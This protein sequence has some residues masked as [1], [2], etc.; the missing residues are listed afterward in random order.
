M[1]KSRKRHQKYVFKKTGRKKTY[2]KGTYKK[3]D[4]SYFKRLQNTVNRFKRA[5]RVTE[6]ERVALNR[7]FDENK[8]NVNNIMITKKDI[9]K[10]HIARSRDHA[11]EEYIFY[12]YDGVKKE[13]AASAFSY[14]NENISITFYGSLEIVDVRKYSGKMPRLPKKPRITEND[15]KRR[16]E[17]IRKAIADIVHKILESPNPILA[18]KDTTK[19]YIDDANM[20]FRVYGILITIKPENRPPIRVFVRPKNSIHIRV[21]RFE[22]EIPYSIFNEYFLNK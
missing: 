10:P 12:L 21:G 3:V 15:I 9:V 6:A 14:D 16:N 8:L 2:K 7:E 20:L 19:I 1:K 5:Y 22:A 11:N 4:V 18:I 17:V 13:N